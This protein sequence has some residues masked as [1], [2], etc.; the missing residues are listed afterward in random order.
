MD[1]FSADTRLKKGICFVYFYNAK[2][3]IC[4]GQA[5][6]TNTLAY[7]YNLECGA[8]PGADL[9]LP[10]TTDAMPSVESRNSCDVSMI[11]LGVAPTKEKCEALCRN[12]ECLQ[13][14]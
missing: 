1:S 7:T 13:V 10:V 12:C 2:K 6:N 14:C 4:R 5:F 9:T 3:G 11:D 8:N